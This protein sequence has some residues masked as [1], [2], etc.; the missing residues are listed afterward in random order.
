MKNYMMKAAGAARMAAVVAAALVACTG[1]GK[2][3]GTQEG[4]APEATFQNPLFEKRGP[5]PWAIYHDG[6]YYYMHTMATKLV[7]W[8]TPDITAVASAPSKTIWQPIDPTNMHNLWAPEIHHLN[9]KWYVLYAADDGNTDNHQ[10]YVLENPSADPMEG[11]FTMKG[12]ISTDPDN[13]WAIDGSYFER[14]GELYMVWSGWQTRRVDDETQCIY[15]ARMKNP[16][17]LASERVIISKPELEWERKYM[18]PDGSMPDHRIYVNEGP[19]PL[20]D[21]DG[22]YI[23]IA[24]S[25]SGCWTPYYALGQ[26]TADA[27]ADLLDPASW[28]KADAPVFR[29][30]PENGVY[31]TGHNS[32]FLS[33]DGTENYI[34]YHARD[35]QTDPPGEGDRRTPR[36]QPFG[37]RGGYPV[38]GTPQ[39]AS[40]R[41]AK[42]SG[43]PAS[44]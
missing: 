14:D 27:G 6:N 23:H 38:F 41:L 2:T 8:K 33:P 7:L 37:W 32:F 20:K 28:H 12:R 11:E 40:T 18:N 30:S 26:L 21:P 19:Q 9:G 34:L 17:T 15:I 35:T 36:M 25:A 5:D 10:L 29:Q 4:E 31:G 43:T 39:P 42:P 22:K 3:T 1:S 24:Y 13:N 44:M 16:W